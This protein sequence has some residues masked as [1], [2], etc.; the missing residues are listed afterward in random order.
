[1]ALDELKNVI[2]LLRQATVV[3]AVICKTVRFQETFAGN[4]NVV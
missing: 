4:D 3:L 2:Q 1:M